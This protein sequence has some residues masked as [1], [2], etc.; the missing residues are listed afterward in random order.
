MLLTPKEQGCVLSKG[1]VLEAAVTRAQGGSGVADKEHWFEMTQGEV[2]SCFHGES[3]HTCHVCAP[4]KNTFLQLWRTKWSCK[5]RQQ[6]VVLL[7][8]TAQVRA[9]RVTLALRTSTEPFPLEKG[10]G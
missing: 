9:E 5:A 6:H 4:K 7:H 2:V 8:C 3:R 10:K 1:M